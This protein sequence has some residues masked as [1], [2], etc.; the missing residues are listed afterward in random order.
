MY[1]QERI[2][3]RLVLI[4]VVSNVL[5]FPSEIGTTFALEATQG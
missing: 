5:W 4:P 3:T 1:I 2:L